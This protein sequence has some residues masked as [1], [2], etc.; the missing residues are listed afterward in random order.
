MNIFAT[1][2]TYPAP[3]SNYRGEK[4]ENRSVIQKVTFGRFEYAVIS[5]EAIKNALREILRK[6]GMKSNRERLENEKQLSVRFNDYPWPE[7]YIDDFFFGYFVAKRDQIPNAI[8]KKR[9][10]QFKRDAILRMNL[11][12][13]VEP[14][15]NDTVFYHRVYNHQG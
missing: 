13:S 5:P 8:V 7:K 3:S 11:A 1:V 12:K 2:L 9:N 4:E 6:Y 14:Y 15:R 10:F